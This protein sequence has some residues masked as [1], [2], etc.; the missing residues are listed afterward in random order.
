MAVQNALARPGNLSEPPR[1]S[2]NSSRCAQDPTCIQIGPTRPDLSPK[3]DFQ[4]NMKFLTFFIDFCGLGGA[5]LAQVGPKLADLG[6]TWGELGPS[7]GLLGPTWAS[8]GPTWGQ[9][10]PTRANLEAAWGQLGSKRPV[11]AESIGF[12]KE[13]EG[14][15]DLGCAGRRSARAR[16]G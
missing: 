13:K 3:L 2:P 8:F 9:L 11:E 10:G 1:W 15:R 12:P 4:K 14:F 6:P 5:K 7:W 16:W